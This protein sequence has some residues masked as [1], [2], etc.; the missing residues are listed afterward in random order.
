MKIGT[1]CFEELGVDINKKLIKINKYS[2]C[3]Q[4]SISETVNIIWYFD[5]RF[6]FGGWKSIGNGQGDKF[7]EGLDYWP[8]KYKYKGDFRNGKRHGFGQFELLKGMIYQG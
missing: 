1:A 7:G 5:G 8:N 2:N 6:Y 3:I 4:Y